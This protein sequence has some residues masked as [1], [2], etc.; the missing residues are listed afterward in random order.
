MPGVQLVYKAIVPALN[1]P[2]TQSPSIFLALFRVAGRCVL[3]KRLAQTNRVLKQSNLS[4]TSDNSPFPLPL[5]PSPLHL[6][7]IDYCREL[8]N[9]PNTGSCY[10]LPP[11]TPFTKLLENHGLYLTSLSTAKSG[12][13]RGD[14]GRGGEER[15]GEGRGVERRGE[16]GRGGR[17]EK[18]E[19]GRH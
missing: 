17:G 11:P 19:G 1:F 8:P 6:S 10:C 14:E 3:T 15:G 12:E 4:A 13:G 5:P 9:D 7:P 16:E 18:E 2:S